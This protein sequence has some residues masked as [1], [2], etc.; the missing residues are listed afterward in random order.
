MQ[1]NRDL[2]E[3][4]F[5]A[6]PVTE[7]ELDLGTVPK[8]AGVSFDKSYAPTALPGLTARTAAQAP[9]VSGEKFDV[10]LDAEGHF[11]PERSTYLVRAEVEEAKLQDLASHNQVAGLYADVTIE[12]TLICPGSPPM[13]TAA[14]VERLLCVPQMHRIGMDGT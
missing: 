5:S 2:A 8:I 4:A 1:Y 13:G 7:K 12:P 14:D 3:I 9:Y 11:D 10:A 6:A